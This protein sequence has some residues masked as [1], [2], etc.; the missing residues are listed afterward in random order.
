MVASDARIVY[1]T[2]VEIEN[3]IMLRVAGGIT[4]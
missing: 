1:P 4:N 3:S 2:Q